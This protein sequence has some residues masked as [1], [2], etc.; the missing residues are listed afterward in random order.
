MITLQHMPRTSGPGRGSR[1]RGRRQSAPPATSEQELRSWF[2]GSIP[3]DW[4]SAPITIVFDRDEIVVSGDLAVPKLN[5]GDDMS[6]A[7]TARIGTFR[8]STRDQRISIAQQAEERF[9]RRVSWEATCADEVSSFTRASTP[10]M[11]RLH[12]EDRQ[13]LDTLIDAGVA[14]SRSEA[15]AWCVRLVADNEAAWLGDLREA[16][17]DLEA[18]RDQGPASRQDG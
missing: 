2:A 8:E 17:T 5:D 7:A 4:F 1:R 12:L 14:R 3:D 15:M 9:K 6:I 13:T 18:L 16:M 11:T 10:V